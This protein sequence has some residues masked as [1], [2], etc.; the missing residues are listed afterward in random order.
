M[1]K[2]QTVRLEP[3]FSSRFLFGRLHN[4]RILLENPNEKISLRWVDYLSQVK[5]DKKLTRRETLHFIDGDPKNTHVSNLV[6]CKITINKNSDTPT[7][8]SPVKAKINSAVRKEIVHKSPPIT[9]EVLTEEYQTLT[10]PQLSEK[11]KVNPTTIYDWI[12]YYNIPLRYSTKRPSKEELEQKLINFKVADLVDHYNVTVATIYTW[13][14]YHKINM[15]KQYAL[16]RKQQ[17]DSRIL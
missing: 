16:G 3:P 10:I 17:S 5:L 14:K 2:P 4:D 7:I 8:S 1:N 11:Y 6:I 9:K 12:K 13:I 15:Y